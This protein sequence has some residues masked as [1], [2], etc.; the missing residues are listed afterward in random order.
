METP[1]KQDLHRDVPG[2]LH[3][4]D[5]RVWIHRL[6]AEISGDSVQS[7]QEHGKHVHRRHRYPWCLYRH[8]HGWLHPQEAPVEASGGCPVGCL[9]QHPLPLLLRY[10]LL[11]R[12]REHEDG[13]SYNAIF[14]Q[15]VPNFGLGR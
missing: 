14:T 9:L 7:V 1:D 8:I 15:K 3:G 5:H 12:L 10:A 13:R 2:G 6:L 4:A 11:F